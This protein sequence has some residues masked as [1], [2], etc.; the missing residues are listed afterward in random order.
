MKSR[1]TAFETIFQTFNEPMAI[2]AGEGM[3]A[4]IAKA[5]EAFLTLSGF[6]EAELGKLPLSSLM[7]STD[8]SPYGSNSSPH[9][10]L[11]AKKNHSIRIKLT[12]R[13]I[14]YNNQPA[15]L[16]IAQDISGAL[17]IHSIIEAGK[18]LIWGF[19]AK[20]LLIERAVFTAP[21]STLDP[22]IA[23][24]QHIISLIHE[25]DQ[26]RLMNEIIQ[27]ASNKRAAQIKL[28]SKRVASMVDLQ[29]TVV[30]SPFYNGDGSLKQFGFVVTGLQ[31]YNEPSDPSTKLKIAMAR[32]NI[33][34][35]QLA[36]LTGIS[37][38]TIS[39]LR[40]G[41]IIKPMRLTA[42]LIASELHLKPEDIW[43]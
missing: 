4:K 8:G 29:L 17:W 38:Q 35:Q 31:P 12:R 10:L 1:L 28:R 18:A 43:G 22:D 25:D 14:E 16:F 39:K 40:N 19:V 32:H 7:I 36:E 5:N 37:M 34:T 13:I 15:V 3:Q 11:H 23:I 33:S 27:A 26:E 2:I 42:E 30:F 9:Y 20:D 24:R 21:I 6:T 41:K